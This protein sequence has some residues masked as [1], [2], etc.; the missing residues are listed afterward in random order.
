MAKPTFQPVHLWFREV[1]KASASRVAVESGGRSSTYQDLE[2]RSNALAALLLENGLAKGTPVVFQCRDVAEQIAAVLGILKAGGLFVPVDP[3]TSEA[4]LGEILRESGPAWVLTDQACLPRLAAACRGLSARPELL[5][6][7]RSAGSAGGAEQAGLAARGFAGVV[8]ESSPAVPVDRDD[9]CYLYFTSGTSGR[10]KAILGRLR[11]ID[12]FIRWEIDALE[13]GEVRGSQLTSPAFDAFLRDVFVPL[14]SGGTVCVPP[15]R[16]VIFDGAELA[17]WLE[18][19]GVEL[20][21]CVPS[22]LRQLPVRELTPERFPRLRWILL[23]GERLLPADVAGWIDV[24]GSRIRLVNLYGPSETTMVKLFH[25]VR[26]EDRD[27]R[28]VPIGRPM[29]GAEAVLLDEHLAVCPPGSV[30]QIVIRTPFRSHGYYR[31]AELTDEVFIANPVT[32]DPEDRVYLTGDYGR[33]HPDGTFEFLG[34]RDQQVKLRGV[35]I[36]L[37][38]V[39]NVLLRYPA[40]SEAVVV[41]RPA[42]DGENVLAAYVTTRVATTVQD[43]ERHCRQNLSEY[44]VPAAFVIL[45][46]LPR[47]LT[48]KIDRRA[49]PAPEEVCATK[50]RTPPQTDVEKR[51]AQLWSTLLRNPDIGLEDDF[52]AAGGHSLLAIQ[53]LAR[54]RQTFE[55]EVPIHRFFQSRTL[56]SLAG[57]IGQMLE[58]HRAESTPT[59]PRAP[60]DGTP[61]PASDAQ[62]RLWFLDRLEPGSPAY[63]V[64]VAVSMEGR[65]SIPAFGAALR[66]LTVRHETLR[67][68]FGT[69]DGQPVQVIDPAVDLSL[70]LVDLSGLGEEAQERERQRTAERLGRLPFDLT[71]SPLARWLLIRR[72]PRRHA[73][74]LVLHHTITDGWSM[75]VLVREVA[76]LYR[77]LAEGVAPALPSLPI[78]YADYACWQQSS[79]RRQAL[80]DDLAFWRRQLGGAPPVLELP[81]DRPRPRRQTYRGRAVPVVV[82]APPMQRLEALAREA[83]AT[84]FM[85]LRAGFHVLASRFSGQTDV[86]IGTVV[87]GRQR[88]ETEDLIGCFAN[89]LA[90]RLE[91]DPRDGFRQL[92]ELT[93]R[94][95]EDAYAHQEVAFEQLVEELQPRRSLSHSPLF[96]VM[97]VLQNAVFDPIELPGLTV[98]GLKVAFDQVRFDLSLELTQSAEGLYGALGY[99]VD[100]F[101]RTTA[102]RMMDQWRNLLDGAV[103]AP[104]CPCGLLSLLTPA[105]RHQAELEWNDTGR[106]WDAAPDLASLVARQV[107]RTPDAVAVAYEDQTLSYAE[108]WRRAERR[109]RHLRHLGRLDDAPVGLL[110]ERSPELLPALLAVILAGAAYLPLDPEHPPE[111]LRSLLDEARPA[112]VL[113][114]HAL[115]GG[116]AGEEVGVPVVVLTADVPEVPGTCPDVDSDQLAYLLYT[117]GSTGRPKGV[118]CHH[119]GIVNRLEWMQATYGLTAG[120]RVLHKTPLLFDVSVWELFWPLITGATLVV[121]PPGVHRESREL[122]RLLARARITTVHF[123]PS[124]LRSLL[125]EPDLDHWDSRRRIIAS[126]EALGRDVALRSRQ[127]LGPVLHNLYGPTEAAVDVSFEPCGDLPGADSTV[128]IGRPVANTTLRV[129]DR[130]GLPAAPRGPGELCIGGVQPARGYL[131]RPALTAESFVPDRFASHPGQRLYR[132]GDLVRQLMDGRLEFLGRLDHQVKLR[133]FRIELEEIEAV[134]G[135]HPAVAEAVVVLDREAGQDRLVAYLLP[136]AELPGR[137]DLRAHLAR[138]LPDYMIPAAF[139]AVTAFPRTP[140]GKL[141]RAAL[142]DR[143]AGRELAGTAEPAVRSWTPLEEIVAGIWASTLG[144]EK[145]E[146]GDSFFSLG[147]HSLLATRLISRIRDQFQVE[148]EV[149]DLFDNL[150]VARCADQIEHAR[151]RGDHQGPPP[152]VAGPREA[153]AAPLSFAQERLWF[154]AQLEPASAAY[155]MPMTLSL[156]GRLRVPALAAALDGVER[157]H[158]ILRTTFPNRD[159]RPVQVASPPRA[160]LLSVADLSGLPPELGAAEVRRRGQ[161]EALRPFDLGRPPLVR[162]LLLRLEEEHHVLLLNL[163]HVLADAWSLELMARETALLYQAQVTGQPFPLPPL[164]LQYGDYA[165]WQRRWLAG[166]VLEREFDHWRQRLAGAP[167]SLDLPTD[168]RR[169]P[170]QTYRGAQHPLAL[171][172]DLHGDLRQLSRQSGCTL[173]MALLAAFQVLLGRYC[174]QRDLL[175]GTPIAHRHDLALEPLIGLFLNTL[176]IRGDMTGDPTFR[177][178]LLRVR[179]ETLNGHAHQHLP[180]SKLV[181]LLDPERSLDRS[182]LFQVLF[183][184]VQGSSARRTELPDLSLEVLPG[185]S[186]TAKFE[187]SLELAES[188]RGL[189]AALEYNIDLF[190]AVTAERL[191]R[192]LEILLRGIVA[193]PDRRISALPLL[194]QQEESHLLARWRGPAPDL[195]AAPLLHERIAAVAGETP[196]AVALEWTDGVMSYRSL[197]ERSRRLA[198]HLGSLGVGPEVLVGLFHPPG[199]DVVVGLLAILTAGGAY[200]PLDPEYPRQRLELMVRDSGLRLLL[201]GEELAEGWP[202]KLGRVRLDAP[203][204]WTGTRGEGSSP[205]ADSLAY[206]IYTSG[207]TGRPKGVQVRHLS[208]VSFLDSMA[209]QPGFTSGDCLAAVTPLSFDI[210]GLELFLPLCSGG[211][212]VLLPR[213][214]LRDRERLLLALRQRRVGVLQATPATWRLLLDESETEPLPLRALCGGEALPTDLARRIAGRCDSAWNLYGPTETTIWSGVW[215][216]DPES[217]VVL[218]RPI[219][220]TRFRLADPRGRLAPPGAVAELAIGGRGLARG[221]LHRP[222]LS[223]QRFV[224]DP[225]SEDPGERL[226]RTGDL[227]RQ[228]PSGELEFLGRLDHQ[229]KIRGHR[230]ELGEVEATLSRHPAVAQ[231]VVTRLLRSAADVRLAAFLV[232]RDPAAPPTAQELRRFLRQ[233]LPEYM[234]PGIFQVVGRL[235]LTPSGKVDRKALHLDSAPAGATGVGAGPENGL[236][237]AVAGIWREVLGVERVGPDDNFFD[238]GGHSLLLPQVRARLRETLGKEVSLLDLFRHPSVARLARHLDPSAGRAPGAPTSRRRRREASSAV[239]VVG[240]AGRFPAAPDLESFWDNLRRGVEAVRFFDDEELRRA[241]VEPERLI[242]PNYVRAR[243]VL[244]DAEL[245]DARFFGF[246]PL[247]AQILDPQHRLCLEVAWEALENAGYEPRSYDGDVALFA[248]TGMNTYA[249]HLLSHPGIRASMDPFQLMISNDKD[250]M[251]TRIAYKLGLTGPAVNVQTACSTSLVA[252]HLACQ[253]LRHG[254]CDMALAGGGAVGVPRASGHPYQEGGILSPDGHCRPF[255]AASRGTVNGEGVAFVVLKPLAAALADGDTIR[256]VIRGSAINNDGADKIGYTAPSVGGQAR[257]IAEALEVAA[258]TADTIDFIETHG[259]ATPLG[260]SIEVAALTEVFGRGGRRR[261]S[262]AL[263]AVKSNIG[264]ADAA[265][266]VAGLIKTVLSLEAAE[267]PPTLHFQRPNPEL[268]LD[269]SPFFVNPELRPWPVADRPRRAGVSSFGV[270]GTNAHLVLEQAPALPA[271][272]PSRPHHLLVLSAREPQALETATDRLARHLEEHPELDTADV[273]Y[274]LQLGRRA[275]RHRRIVV[276]ESLAGAVEALRRRRSGEVFDAAEDGQGGRPVAFLFAGVGEQYPQMGR[277]LYE[278]EDVFRRELDRCCDLLTPLLGS[279]PRTMLYPEG[280]ARAADKSAGVDLRRLVGRGSGEGAASSPLDRTVLAQPVVCALEIALARQWQAWGIEPEAVLGYSLGEYSAAC[281]AGVLSVEDA[282]TVVA[283]RARLIESLP[284]G[285]MLAVPLPEAQVAAMLRDGAPEEALD[286]AVVAHPGLTVVAGPEAAVARLEARL[287]EGE[288]LCRRLKTRHAFHSRMMEPITRSFA[289]VVGKVD[290]RPPAIP[291]LSNVTGTWMTARE[292][293]DPDYWVRHLEAT[294]RFSQGLAQ[295]LADPRQVLLEIG[296]GQALSTTARQHPAAGPEH[297]VLASLRDER[298]AESDVG[299]L[300]RNLG[301]LWLAGVAVDWRRLYAQKPR[302]RRLPLPTYPFQR[303]RYWVDKGPARSGDDLRRRPDLADWFFHP[304]WRRTLPP[305][306]ATPGEGATWLLFADSHGV[307]E[308]LA[309]ELRRHRIRPVLVRSAPGGEGDDLSLDPGRPEEYVRLLQNLE[310]TGR[311]PRRILHLWSLCPAA[312]RPSFEEVQET[313]FLSLL[314]LARALTHHPPTAMPTLDVLSNG[315]HAVLGDEELHPAA[316]TVLGAASVI[317]QELPGA[318]TR[319]VDLRLPS[320][321]SEA[322]TDALVAD[323]LTPADDQ[324]VVAWRGSQRWTRCFENVAIAEP[325]GPATLL[326]D[327]GVYLITGGL[328]GLGRLFSL[329]LARHHRARLVLVHRSPASTRERMETLRECQALGSETLVLQADVADEEA[330][331]R[332]VEAAWERFG[333]I[334]GVIHAAGVPGGALI[335]QQSREQVARV[336]G[337]KAYGALN[338]ERALADHPPLDF[339]VLFSSLSS[340]LGDV[341]GIDYAAANAFLDAFGHARNQRGQRTVVINWCTWSETGMVVGIHQERPQDREIALALQLGLPSDQG[342]EA[343]RRILERGVPQVAVSTQNLQAQFDDRTARLRPDPKDDTTARGEVLLHHPRPALA[344]SYAAPRT[345]LEQMLAET[346]REVLLVDE[347]GV[348]DNFVELGGDSL[349]SLQVVA[350]ARKHDLRLS[351]ALIFDH[352]TV[353]RLAAALEMPADRPEPSPAAPAGERTSPDLAGFDPQTVEDVCF[354]SPMQE[355]LLFHALLEP[356][357]DVYLRHLSYEI[358][359]AVDVKLFRRAWQRVVDRHSSLR[360]GFLWEQGKDARQV[361][362]RCPELPFRFDDWSSFSPEKQ[363]A[364]T[365]ELLEADLREPFELR[366]PPLVRVTLAR[367]ADRRFLCLWTF[368]HLVVDGWSI[369]RVLAEVAEIYVALCRNRPPELPEPFEYRRYVEWVRRQD[370]AAAEAFWRR[371]L[372]GF[373]APTPLS[374]GGR[375]EADP[376]R[377]HDLRAYVD[378]RAADS[379]RAWA[380]RH[381][382]TASSLF[383]GVWSLL[384]SRYSGEPDVLFG[385]VFSGRPDELPGVDACVGLLIN[386]LPLRVAVLPRRPL[387]PWLQHLQQQRVRLHRYQYSPLAQIQRRSEVD[388]GV[389]LFHSIMA[390]QDFPRLAEA[391]G[392]GD[393]SLEVS[394]VRE[395]NEVTHY[396]VTILAQSERL[397]GMRLLFDRRSFDRT[398]AERVKGHLE[399]LLRALPEGEGRRLCE[400][401]WLT[402]AERHQLLTEC[403]DTAGGEPRG[404]LIHRLFEHRAAAGP[405]A[406]ATLCGGV[407]LSYGEL[408]ARANRR[409]HELRRLGLRPGELVGIHLPRGTEIVVA[410]LAVLKAG[411]AYVPL[412]TS[413]PAAR[414]RWIVTSLGLRFLLSHT[415][416]AT[417]G[418]ALEH[419]L[420]LDQPASGSPPSSAPAPVT[421]ADDLAY[422]IF[423]SGSTGTP[424]GVMVGHRPVVRLIRWVNDTFKVGEDDRLLFLTA[425]SFDLSVYDVYGVLAAGG[426]VDVATGEELAEPRLLVDALSERRITFWDSAPAALQQLVPDFPEEDLPSSAGRSA[427][428][429]AFVSGD[430]IPLSLPGAVRRAFPHCQVV[431]L[432]GA[433]EATVWSNFHPVDRIDPKWV[434]IPYGRPIHDARYHV[435]DPGFGPCSIGVAGDLH[436]GGQCLASGYAGDAALSAGKFLPDPFAGVAGARLYATGDRAR[437][438]AD[439]V[440]EFLGRLDHQVKIRGFRIELGE[441][442]ACLGEH[443]AV[444]TAVVLARGETPESKQLVAFVEP[445]LSPVRPPGGGIEGERARAEKLRRFLEERLPPYMVPA[446]ILLLDAIPVTANG[447]VDRQALAAL[448]EERRTRAVRQVRLP[449]DGLELELTELWQSLLEIRPVGLDDNF[450]DLGGHSVLAVRLLAHVRERFAY[451]LSLAELLEA[452]TVEALARHLRQRSGEAGAEDDKS[453]VTL[454]R[455]GSELPLFLIHPAGGTVTCF[456]S[457]AQLLGRRRPVYGL[458]SRGLQNGHFLRSI[459]DMA[460]AYL[461]EIRQLL[462]EGPYCLAGWSLGGYVAFE[463][464]RRL[465][466]DHQPVGLLALLD[467]TVWDPDEGE[468]RPEDHLAAFVSEQYPELAQEVLGET[469]VDGKLER[470]YDRLASVGQLPPD[471][472]PGDFRRFY[473]LYANN[474]QAVN[475]YTPHHYPGVLTAFATDVRSDPAM[476]WGAFVRHVET[477]PIPGTHA[478]VLREPN[479]AFLAA[480]L[481]ECLKTWGKS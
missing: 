365:E 437:Y 123:V 77:A 310:Q 138:H 478:T 387:V 39:E 435:L 450:F 255:D 211:R 390:L 259:T 432:G 246:S 128:P 53:L 175:V 222:A 317:P 217:E 328:G 201:S 254:E 174:G 476:G 400:L 12:H 118:M 221:Y 403:N 76:R 271:T 73:V 145:V 89:T 352:P 480:R 370:Q 29:R 380:G 63:N 265:A 401:P 205:Q 134:L 163:H 142:L 152:L 467:T 386:T 376:L 289:E 38:G 308:A 94:N 452:G 164:A 34:R 10:P 20:V 196:D 161:S 47:T 57:L 220:H 358:A 349:L 339:M 312:A 451:R 230:I 350:R 367:L 248:G 325:S 257:A 226:Y 270:G 141:D 368:H 232:P 66:Q 82:E 11:G 436:I 19:S 204:S 395:S 90:L 96:Q 294:V 426:A 406:V 70:P 91:A 150:T 471:F 334:D 183:T 425:L 283:Q 351:L 48:G 188:T 243:A 166:E 71:V 292:A 397:L 473:D 392:G 212:L 153:G 192:W 59:L 84:L 241:G 148:L 139:V 117:S 446:R 27:L 464:A 224:P 311:F 472:R 102:R 416:L 258:V 322:V 2:R 323:L 46:E 288:V 335:H 227:V 442:E 458:Q 479:V 228:E 127:R 393:P 101:D 402:V 357:A 249:V 55:L 216:V 247:E 233:E 58:S 374:Q 144:V 167:F 366:R 470:L 215:P 251:P 114:R 316:A 219:A 443:P 83:A 329:F 429:L 235:P 3:G 107:A 44:E 454:A 203:E 333:T 106:R 301:R 37:T 85:V 8:A 348:H 405:D 305:P 110:L 379:I 157:R 65:L 171:P 444:R 261:G 17:R 389:S 250:F 181:E 372:A 262:C 162:T 330:L 99:N 252:T 302:R 411:G 173:F 279:D 344:T 474:V 111:R 361:I 124:M 431:S 459:K 356:N 229:V 236:Q 239:A 417:E 298:Q 273:A 119:R 242:Q 409:A 24:F 394:D 50:A 267:I 202:G 414:R 103:T 62:R 418:E 447:K 280:P 449:R 105:Q 295:L 463:M 413:F 194:D 375:P 137:E 468:A 45:G 430:W 97:L 74:V 208:L 225:E 182:P 445:V 419:V 147:G 26:P 331:K 275:F 210:A 140:S 293:T 318:R 238:L 16:G 207:S 78:Q 98:Q 180:F 314:F 369:S 40:V 383:Y 264:H 457:L 51:L 327:R 465:S 291:C 93:R 75:G 213:D 281:I 408:E 113:S 184:L 354:L 320:R 412:S 371:E 1:A 116:W 41:E 56:G 332:A 256:A 159:G 129:L 125:D 195:A 363:A 104:D 421:R 306:P 290:L 263:G 440:L 378:A 381:G 108:L 120:E 448:E 32:G 131:R 424:K 284:P 466:A 14:C 434:S 304:T 420:C 121:A 133:G 115:P 130:E 136:A 168:H 313:G 185:S 407:H 6:F 206:V 384:L 337:P 441:I 438:G 88:L 276:A 342:L 422:V 360:T 461:D 60:R 81:T 347:I 72:R 260:D 433:T 143:P 382:L 160:R 36:E 253:S 439:G 277:E 272:D 286:V 7:D 170:L 319:T 126:G 178:L 324:P 481:E 287:A 223:A 453:L 234:V 155:N 231:A 343:F 49:L 296:P 200:V 189:S 336:F 156:K 31:A 303:R 377:A 35:R 67:T 415:S 326:R 346:W 187:L 373:T 64:P 52:F 209:R 151:R 132:T 455:G 391:A 359:A 198:R 214:T 244:D 315:L 190:E 92:L 100:L 18:E 475:A 427:L 364:L 80:E 341:G 340:F 355:G 199:P 122:A 54:I 191:C 285:A 186:R 353:A 28:S 25:F 240:M 15:E 297:V 321:P 165:R 172:A 456:W 149:R 404:D 22:V 79:Q 477:C 86:V 266:G 282:L 309:Q 193:Q 30:G 274:T 176:V 135:R 299:R 399:V 197:I 245:F 362:F 42:P 23:S 154:L 237:G 177:E 396:R 33:Q 423:T 460:V 388:R 410:L 109:A 4:R 398:A 345:P 179:E 158:E 68:R 385:T 169:P 428:R 462:P 95:T 13:L 146:P 69:V 61:L 43:L 9:P 112:L 307:A 218:G 5:I 21:H 300:L 338:L 268:K 278:H 469:H 87:A 269:E